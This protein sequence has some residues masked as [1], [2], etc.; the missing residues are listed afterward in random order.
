MQGPQQC[1]PYADTH[2]HVNVLNIRLS[3]RVWLST[4]FQS[5]VAGDSQSGYVDAHL[6]AVVAELAQIRDS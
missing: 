2:F 5:H 3:R 4:A 6:V 1:G